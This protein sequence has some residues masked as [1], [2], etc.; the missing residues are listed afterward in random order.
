MLLV[1]AIGL[2]AAA[3][4]IY[5]LYQLRIFWSAVS[6]SKKPKAN[7]IVKLIPTI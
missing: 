1:L 7:I 5:E 6:Q 4:R 2:G 3:V